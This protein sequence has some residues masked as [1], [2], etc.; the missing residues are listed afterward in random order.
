MQKKKKIHFSLI[1]L[2][3]INIRILVALSL[4]HCRWRCFYVI[5]SAVTVQCV[6]NN[7][8]TAFKGSVIKKVEYCVY[9]HLV[10]FVSNILKELERSIPGEHLT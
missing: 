8:S 5:N 9:F 2:K 3:R 1:L 10:C 7:K 4:L 6:I